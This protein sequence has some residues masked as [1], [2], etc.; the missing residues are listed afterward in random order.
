VKKLAPRKEWKARFDEI[1]A[2]ER[3]L[4]GAGCIV[5]KYF[6]H[7]DRDEQEKRLLAREDDPNDAWKLNIEDWRDR[8][9]W[10]AFTE[11]Y[12]EALSK[13]AAADAPWIV[14]PANAK[15]YRNLVMAESLAKAM[16]PYRREWRR[17]L[18]EEGKLVRKDLREW[19]A[20]RRR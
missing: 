10:D 18:D 3:T 9:R 20:S 7:I 12:D 5:L 8:E 16:R 13:C 6:L 14:V 4:A 1:N 17:T 19:R 15:W 2:F 11:A